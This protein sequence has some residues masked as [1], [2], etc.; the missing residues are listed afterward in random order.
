MKRTRY[1][2]AERSDALPS[3]QP[4][5]GWTSVVTRNPVKPELFDIEWHRHVRPYG[6]QDNRL[7]SAQTRSQILYHHPDVP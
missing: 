2:R 6:H 7:W 5:E 3:P 4:V 1:R